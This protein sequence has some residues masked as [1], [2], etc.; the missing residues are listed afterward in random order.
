M[1]QHSVYQSRPPLNDLAYGHTYRNN[2]NDLLGGLNFPYSDGQ[3]QPNQAAT[4]PNPSK[5]LPTI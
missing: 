1:P 4:L 3:Q 2:P 5:P